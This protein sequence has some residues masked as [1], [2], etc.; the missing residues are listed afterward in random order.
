VWSAIVEAAPKGA[1]AGTRLSNLGQFLCVSINTN[2]PSVENKLSMLP[3]C[4]GSRV[5]YTVSSRVADLS[6]RRN[7]CKVSTEHSIRPIACL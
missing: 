7:K 1:G 3:L 5:A 4:S 2:S 6:M